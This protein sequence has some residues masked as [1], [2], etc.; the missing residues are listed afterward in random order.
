MPLGTLQVFGSGL[1]LQPQSPGVQDVGNFNASGVGIAAQ[2]TTSPGGIGASNDGE[3]FGHGLT[4]GT[5]VR[6][7][8]IGSG[9]T[10][11][12]PAQMVNVGYNSSV[13]CG[14][15]VSFGQA[16]TAGYVGDLGQQKVALGTACGA[17]TANGAPSFHVAVGCQVTCNGTAYTAAFG[18]NVSLTGSQSGQT[19]F[20][21]GCLIGWGNTTYV[22]NAVL[23]IGIQQTGGTVQNALVVGVWDATGHSGA[24]PG[25]TSDSILI[26]NAAQPNVKI[27]P[28]TLGQSR[29]TTFKVAD[30][31][32][33]MPATEGVVM[34]TSITAA[35]TVT[36]PAANAV[37][38]GT[39]IRIVDMSGSVT[40][41]NNITILPAGADTIVGP[42]T[43]AINAAYG[44]DRLMSDGVSKWLD[45]NNF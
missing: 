5:G 32:H 17:G 11:G 23:G 3:L 40:G 27:G 39:I 29:G 44:A 9:L 34:Y 31:N 38:A 19:Q 21:A 33:V 20:A 45:N 37:P 30:A 22:E 43:P 26:G 41:V 14:T 36:L 8:L 2:F 16:N 24:F 28:Y 35:R 10:C 6:Q 7:I 1:R 4:K 25:T 42:G 13:Y 15:S 12:N 18:A